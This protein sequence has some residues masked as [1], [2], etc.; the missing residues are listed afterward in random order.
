MWEK[1]KLIEQAIS[2]FSTMF[3]TLSRTEIIIL[4]NLIYRLQMLC[5]LVRSKILSRG[6]G[7]N[8]HQ[9]F[10]RKLRA[11]KALFWKMYLKVAQR[12]HGRNK[13]LVIHKLAFL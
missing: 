13:Y 9:P 11:F 2:L 6:N 1:E 3:S 7:L 8:E 10:L 5:N 4:L 12:I